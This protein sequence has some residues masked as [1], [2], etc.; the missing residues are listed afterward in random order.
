ME[1]VALFASDNLSKLLAFTYFFLP[2]PQTRLIQEHVRS[3]WLVVP[4]RDA[5]RYPPGTS[6]VHRRAVKLFLKR[7]E[8]GMV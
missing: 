3:L 4:A 6:F 7:T 1:A 5:N 8:L 2:G